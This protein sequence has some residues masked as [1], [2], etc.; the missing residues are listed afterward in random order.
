MKNLYSKEVN[1]FRR[2]SPDI[3]DLYGSWGNEREGVFDVP[4]GHMS[5][6]LKVIASNDGG[7]DHVSASLP[8]RCPTWDEMNMLKDLFFMPHEL[9]VQFHPP[10][11]MYINHHPYTLH[12]WRPHK[13]D[14]QLP[15]SW[16]V[17]P[18]DNKG[19]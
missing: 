10:K 5:G 3:I 11:A 14:I 19:A 6:H 16:M 13:Q 17:G 15:P 4:C 12:L 2:M 1:R 8:D 7:W 9:V 18:K